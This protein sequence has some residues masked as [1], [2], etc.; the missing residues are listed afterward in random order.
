M[1]I[2]NF[3]FEEDPFSKGVQGIG[4]TYHDVLL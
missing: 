3:I 4:K 1:N 2:K